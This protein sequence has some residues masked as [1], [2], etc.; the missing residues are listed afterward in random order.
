MQEKAFANCIQ[1]RIKFL[2]EYISF[3][4]ATGY[5]GDWRDIVVRF[6]PNL[7]SDD[8]LTAQL[9]TTLGDKLS[10]KTGLSLLSFIENPE[11]EEDRIETE[12]AKLYGNDLLEVYKAAGSDLVE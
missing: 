4:S 2:F 12:Q 1:S 9:I 7:P 5:K 10:T 6:T 11:S 8:L 3:N